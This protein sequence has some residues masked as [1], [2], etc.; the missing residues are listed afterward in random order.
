[1]NPIF[2]IIIFVGSFIFINNISDDKA[3]PLF[4]LLP[5]SHTNITFNNQIKDT[6]EHNI[7]IYSNFYGGAGVGIGDFNKDGLPDI[8]FAGNLVE[9]QLYLNKGNLQFEEVTDEAGIKDNGGWSSGAIVADVNQDGWLDIYVT[10]EL[11][12]DKP[13]LRKNL[14]YIN[15]GLDDHGTNPSLIT[16]KEEAEQ[17]GL[18]D[19]A[20]TRHATF[21]DYDNDGDLDLF[22]LNQPPNPGDYSPFYGTELLQKQYRPKLYENMDGNFEDVSVKAGFTKTGFPNSVS[23][24]DINGDGW[25]DLYVAND[26]WVADWY[27]INN[28]DGTFTDK[29]PDYTRHISYFSMGV[30]AADINNDGQLDIGVLDMVAEDNFR[31]KANMS[32]MNPAAFWKVVEDGGHYQYMFNTLHLNVGDGYLSDIAQLGGVAATD[33]SWSVL[34]ADWDNDGWKDMFITNGLMRDIRNK[35]ASK[36]FADQ[37]ESAVFKYLQKN[38]NNPENKGIWDIV[39]VEKA[40]E[41]TPSEKLSNYIFKNNGDLTFSKKMDDWGVNQ[42]T[43]SN[44]ASYADL[45]NDG[46]LDLVV[47]NINDQAFVYENQAS[48]QNYLRIHPLADEKGV[49]P[50]G[51]KI[52]ISTE[53]GNQFC[54]ITNVRGMYS[55]S[56]PVA[57]FGLGEQSNVNQVK[58][59]WPDG[60]SVIINNVEAN[61][62]LTVK[63]SD[64]RKESIEK[65]SSSTPLMENKT[66][67]IGLE[68]LHRENPFDDYKTQVLLPH[69]MSAFGPCLATGDVNGDELEDFFV[70]SSVGNVSALYVQKTD[71]TFELVNNETFT[72]DKRHEDLGAAFFDADNDKDLD[73]YVVSGGNE[74][75]SSSKS[76]QDRLYLNDGAGNF[77]KAT[78]QLPEK[79]FSGSKVRPMDIDRDGDIDL[80]VAG[81]H[82]PWSYPEPASS[83]LLINEGG[84][85]KD[86][87]DKIAPG[88]KDIGIVNDAAWFDYDNDGWQDLLLVGE[89]MPITIFKNEKGQLSSS[90]VALP[91]SA[92][93]WFSV[94]TADMDGDGDKDIIA[95]NLGLNYKY[96]ATEEEPF[97]IY[98]YDFDDNDSKDIVLTYYNYGIQYP[99]RGRQCSSEQVPEIKEKFENYNIFASATTAEVYG[100]DKLE[101]ALHYEAHTFAS[102]YFENQ[103]D[104]NFEAHPLPVL[105]QLSSV[106]D[107]LIND[108]NKDGHLDLILAGNLYDAEVETTRNDAGFG[109]VLTGDGTGKFNTMDRHE[110]GFF[111]PYN[112]KS[113]ASL[114]H[115]Q[116]YFILVGCNNAPLQIFRKIK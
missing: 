42:K 74:F 93:W 81:R 102:T 64:A 23:A 70:G 41:V 79:S 25:T 6:K 38:P 5:A 37:I 22:L 2:S 109:L 87:T 89:W 75:L 66:N 32:G 76:Y 85:F 50:F 111:V 29:L 4:R 54:E 62:V 14:L 73:L 94:S 13:Q 45:D 91:S 80:F 98:Y 49:V 57:H 67:T 104:G 106:N 114:N 61:Q 63:Y 3:T 17:Y 21:L 115:L 48:G 103:G 52:W 59:Q 39:D 90:P 110:S 95:G 46:D 27:Y 100:E 44:G 65:K 107:I 83:M 1:M 11:Y 7:M 31:Q 16:F 36:K 40:L 18:A 116:G 43:F 26:F 19:T 78:N 77:T 8:F 113:M 58:I 82:I 20:R 53:K 30:D 108:I 86:A 60:R 84:Q 10:R 55:T 24:S 105:A 69:K 72:K 92:G 112:V 33:W 34:L 71:G 47:S 56:E 97:E 12:D 15:Q 9:D 35:D 51:T 88:L 99:L 28:G 96:K 101:N 68:H